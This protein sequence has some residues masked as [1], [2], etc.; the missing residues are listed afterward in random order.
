[1]ETTRVESFGAGAPVASSRP[2]T[3]QSATTRYTPTFASNAF[4]HADYT[5]PL[6][7]TESAAVR[8]LKTTGTSVED[9]GRRNQEWDK[10]AFRQA[11][12]AA[13][14]PQTANGFKREVVKVDNG[15]CANCHNHEMVRHQK[16]QS[17]L[18]R[19]SLRAAEQERARLAQAQE[20]AEARRM[21][22]ARDNT[23]SEMNLTMSQLNAQRRAQWEA[24]KNDKTNLEQTE[25]LNREVQE[26]TQKSI[27]D[28][29]TLQQMYRDELNQKRNEVVQSAV[30]Q[31]NEERDIE[32]SLKGLTFECYSRDQ[33]M[34]DEVKNTGTFQKDQIHEIQT[35]KQQ[36]KESIVS[37]P[38]VF[39]TDKELA[40]LRAEAE[41]RNHE[42][43][44]FSASVAND[45]LSQ[46][47][48]K[49]S[50]FESERRQKIAE[51][52]AHLQRLRQL[53]DQDKAS[54]RRT[55]AERNQEMSSTLTA[56]NQRKAADWEA[57]RTDISNKIET[58][59]LQ[60]EI[61]ELTKASIQDNLKQK[62][63]YH[64]DLNSI[65]Q[66]KRARLSQDFAVSREEEAKSKGLTFECYTRDPQ[67]KEAHKETRGYL[68]QQK[69]ME[70]LRKQQERESMIQPPPSLVTT[71]QLNEMHQESVNQDLERRSHLK[72]V[73][74]S[75]YKETQEQRAAR[76]A[77]ERSEDAKEASRAA[78]ENEKYNHF[79]KEQ[80]L[81][82]KV[83][84]SHYLSS[85]LKEAETK[86][87]LEIDE[88]R[89][90]P[91]VEKLVQENARIGE[92]I[93]KCGKC[94]C[95]LAHEKTIFNE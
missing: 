72:K 20:E 46:H 63:E 19:E 62:S 52:E 12:V 5:A 30:Q 82:N 68:Q 3:Q 58:E 18:N 69:E 67:M 24:K 66:E 1:M 35:R 65:T 22:A 81:A 45:Q 86:R 90:D 38:E 29:V 71:Q 49:I 85:Q 48:T 27:Q 93:V 16:T 94:E 57:K 76:I 32:R 60:N 89:Y 14:K 13:G 25:K 61:S 95:T 84:Y 39:Y 33:Q 54:K 9:Y 10:N 43:R 53:E 34:R 2:Q 28:R 31:K 11:H 64:N 21:R 47:K 92:K 91:N 41:A 4:G 50:Q 51:E 77:A 44:A 23:N 26:L 73:M 7:N 15:D 80:T 42:Q 6:K 74:T 87:K 56:I 37:P 70:N 75:Q 83:N 36:E 55:K 88:R 78:Y 59:K 40:E 17:Q 8:T 79:Q